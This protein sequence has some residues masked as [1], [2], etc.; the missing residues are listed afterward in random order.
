MLD[1]VRHSVLGV[2]RS[3]SVE[4]LSG[5]ASDTTSKV[6]SVKIEITDEY[7]LL[8]QSVF[9]PKIKLL[10]DG[11][12]SFIQHANLEAW[13]NGDD[14]NGRVYTIHLTIMDEAGNSIIAERV[15]LVPHDKSK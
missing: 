15:V 14:L 9:T 6:K 8:E 2:R 1:A 12:I 4:S 7:R 11:T 13:R 3:P 10:S 5:T